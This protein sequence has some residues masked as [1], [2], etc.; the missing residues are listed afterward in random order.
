MKQPAY[1]CSDTIGYLKVM[2]LGKPKLNESKEVQS[3][4]QSSYNDEYSGV[5]S[6]SIENYK[7]EQLV[8]KST[9]QLGYTQEAK[10]TSIEKYVDKFKESVYPNKIGSSSSKS[11]YD[12]NKN[13]FWKLVGVAFAIEEFPKKSI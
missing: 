13:R 7:A 9:G 5:S 1:A 4:A 6:H 10:F 8:G 2:L 12:N 11:N 3:K